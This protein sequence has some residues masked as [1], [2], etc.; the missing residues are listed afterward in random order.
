MET[1]FDK[2][3]LAKF[4]LEIFQAAGLRPEHAAC[5]VANLVA[6]ELRGVRSHGLI[7]VKNYVDGLKSGV[8]NKN[9]RIKTLKDAP[10]AVLIDGD[11]APGAVS[12][13]CAMDKCI[14]KAK[15]T[16]MAGAAVKNGT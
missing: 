11:A 12:G 2:E 6:A 16:G 1:R 4:C 10:S 13:V 8:I 3:K 9:P 15:I 7:Q 14:E 5:V